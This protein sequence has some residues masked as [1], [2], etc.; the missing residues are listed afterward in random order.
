MWLFLNEHTGPFV[1]GPFINPVLSGAPAEKGLLSC[2]SARTGA[3]RVGSSPAGPAF[4]PRV[5]PPRSTKTPSSSSRSSPACG[6]KSRRRK[7]VKGRRVRRKRRARRKARSR[8]V[9]LGRGGGVRW[10][11]AAAHPPGWGK[12]GMG[13]HPPE[14]TRSPHGSQTPLAPRCHALPSSHLLSSWCPPQLA[15]SK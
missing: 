9:S 14:G 5:F 3:Q 1:W 6:R 8:S 4:E 11:G 15:R 7:T 10:G 2:P 13:S 12:A